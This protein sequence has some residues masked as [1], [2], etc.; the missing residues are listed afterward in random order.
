MTDFSVDGMRFR[1]S[2]GQSKTVEICATDSSFNFSFDAAVCPT[3]VSCVNH[4]SRIG[5]LYR[6]G[7]EFCSRLVERPETDRT[8]DSARLITSDDHVPFTAESTLAGPLVGRIDK[9]ISAVYA[10]RLCRQQF[11]VRT[12]FRVV[13][14]VAHARNAAELEKTN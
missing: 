8:N 4:L 7:R 10:T 3:S 2:F 1:E 13:E 9:C 14:C 6:C 11:C 12:Q 5:R